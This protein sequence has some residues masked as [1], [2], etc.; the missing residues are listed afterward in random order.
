MLLKHAFKFKQVKVI[1]YSTCSIY[2][3]ENEM[4]IKEAL[5]MA[6]Q[7]H[8]HLNVNTIVILIK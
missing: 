7:N 3:E 5:T 8:F 1:V 2:N 6:H 4:V